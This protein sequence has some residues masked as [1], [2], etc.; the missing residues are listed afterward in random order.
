MSGRVPARARPSAYLC[1]AQAP[2]TGTW[3]AWLLYTPCCAAR[4]SLAGASPA[5][6]GYPQPSGLHRREKG[7]AVLTLYCMQA[8][9]P[10]FLRTKV[11]NIRPTSKPLAAC[12]ERSLA[13]VETE[14]GGVTL[15]LS[16]KLWNGAD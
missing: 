16:Q 7:I 8:V 4:F 9:K 1:Q 11:A 13:L 14:E 2:L 15:T 10:S 5:S 6:W 12:K 3:D